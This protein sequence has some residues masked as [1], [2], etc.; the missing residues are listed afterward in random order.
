MPTLSPPT[1]SPTYLPSVSLTKIQSVSKNPTNYPSTN[2]TNIPSP[3]H[4]P[5]YI[6]TSKPSQNPSDAS[7]KIHEQSTTVIVVSVMAAA[8]I[9][10]LI[11]G[12]CVLI[13]LKIHQFSDKNEN[14][15]NFHGEKDDANDDI[16]ARNLAKQIEMSSLH[17]IPKMI[18]INN[19]E[20]EEKLDNGNE[21][22][23]NDKQIRVTKMG[24]WINDT[25]PDAENTIILTD[26]MK[27]NQFGTQAD[28][29]KIDDSSQDNQ[30]EGICIDYNDV[31][32][33]DDSQ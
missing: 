7:F 24:I 18:I 1:Q 13:Y 32:D 4:N 14:Y 21:D 6:P 25:D 31:K 11:L 5:T 19:I 9:L 22:L 27:T 12:I 30:I 16:E 15:V 33:T 10:C 28:E 3:T 2:P 23:G 17:A 8:A 26:G 20:K 29:T